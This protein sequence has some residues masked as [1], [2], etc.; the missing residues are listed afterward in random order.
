MT[1]VTSNAACLET[2]TP[3]AWP[4]AWYLAAMLTS[5]GITCFK[6]YTLLCDLEAWLLTRHDSILAWLDT[7]MHYAFCTWLQFRIWEV[8][9][10]SYSDTKLNG[11]RTAL[12]PSK[13]K[14]HTTIAKSMVRL[15]AP[16]MHAVYAERKDV[17]IEL[18]TLKLATPRTGQGAWCQMLRV[19]ATSN[20]L[21]CTETP[22]QPPDVGM[23]PVHQAKNRLT[24]QELHLPTVRPP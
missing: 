8:G 21:D 6:T 24:W 23:K 11:S 2:Q 14:R 15:S 16:A 22:V 20:E 17:A 1:C 18:R 3:N 4:C 19:G 7:H 12:N 9:S 5:Y 13:C 10:V